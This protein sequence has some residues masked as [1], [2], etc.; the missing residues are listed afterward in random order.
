MR[1]INKKKNEN[2]GKIEAHRD[3]V[4]HQLN[5]SSNANNRVIYVL[6]HIRHVNDMIVLLT[7]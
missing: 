1:R 7:Q 3:L 6:E 2:H 4:F 5:K